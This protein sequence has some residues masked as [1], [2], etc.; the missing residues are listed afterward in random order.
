MLLV[1]LVCSVVYHRPTHMFLM[2]RWI[3]KQLIRMGHRRCMSPL[4]LD[5][6]LQWVLNVRIRMRLMI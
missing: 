2:S 1:R 5:R 3:E 6:P 4:V